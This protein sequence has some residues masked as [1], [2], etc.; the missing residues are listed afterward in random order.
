MTVMIRPVGT[1]F[2]ISWAVL[3]GLDVD[4]PVHIQQYFCF[5]D[6]LTDAMELLKSAE[7]EPVPGDDYFTKKIA[8]KKKGKPKP[9]PGT[10]L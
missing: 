6:A 5:T 10:G 3:A 2:G 9:P 7:N 4:H 8:S 1:V